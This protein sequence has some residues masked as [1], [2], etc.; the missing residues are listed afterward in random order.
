M[1][2]RGS[3]Q[4]VG[5]FHQLFIFVDPPDG[6]QQQYGHSQYGEGIEIEISFD[7]FAGFVVIAC[8][9]GQGAH[10]VYGREA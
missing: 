5:I 4:L 2:R 6:Q 10:P 9:E 3:S 8:D 7:E 1:N